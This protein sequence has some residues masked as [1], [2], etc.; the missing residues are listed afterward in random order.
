MEQFLAAAENMLILGRSPEIIR[1]S[2][3]TSMVSENPAQARKDNLT[4]TGLGLRATPSGAT[5]AR[6]WITSSFYSLKGL[7]ASSS[8]CLSTPPVEL[9]Q[10]EPG[11]PCEQRNRRSRPRSLACKLDISFT[12][13]PL[14]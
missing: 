8:L 4:T 10:T 7:R 2:S 5:S 14:E 9:L 3:K 13:L 6:I 12:L 11:S 1:R